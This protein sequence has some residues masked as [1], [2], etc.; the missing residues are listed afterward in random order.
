MHFITNEKVNFKIYLYSM[1]NIIPKDQETML[2]KFIKLYKNW[3][4]VKNIHIVVELW[5]V[6][7]H[8]PIERDGV[9]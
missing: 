1:F 3:G 8:F 4:L 9:Y 5:L 7:G 2:I 6:H